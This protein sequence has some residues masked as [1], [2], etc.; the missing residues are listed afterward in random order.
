MTDP[1]IEKV[2]RVLSEVR[3][4]VGYGGQA[5]AAILVVRT[6]IAAEIRDNAERYRAAS[7]NTDTADNY[8][9]G[10]R[11]GADIAEGDQ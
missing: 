10:M 7:T 9:R 6:H 2:A 3:P 4:V 5:D 11:A 1:L 8:V